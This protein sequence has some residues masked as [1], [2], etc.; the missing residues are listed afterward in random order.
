VNI[1]KEKEERGAGEIAELKSPRKTEKHAI[2]VTFYDNEIPDF[3]ERELERLYQSVYCTI[4]RFNIYGE[5]EGASTYVA[6]V[7]GAVVAA[8]LFRVEAGI[9]RV[10]NQQVRLSDDELRRFADAVFARYGA[11]RRIAFYA[12]DTG[13]E[14][15][16]LPF[17]R[18]QALEENILVLPRTRGDY[19]ASLNQ[20]LYKRLQSGERKLKRDYPDH[21]FRILRGTEVTADTLRQVVAMAS[22][23]MA[24]KHQDTYIRDED[25]DKI[26][27]LIHA[28]GYVGALTINGVIRGGNVFY[29]VGGRYFMHVIAHDPDY[30]KYML[31]HMVQYLSACYCIDNGGTEC[32]LMGGGREN[33]GRFRAYPKYLDSVD[34]YR[35]RLRFLLDARRVVSGTLRRYLYRARE[36]FLQ[37][38]DSD[39]PAGLRA[40]KLLGFVRRLKK[41]WRRTASE[42]K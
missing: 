4:A 17:L 27:R 41:G 2:Q 30:D 35:S 3:V 1:A 36:D 16:H 31:G 37:L 38:A 12:I 5:A 24:S 33:K 25:V 32:C 13:L 29:G 19:T 28:Y 26:L 18:Y 11:A 8:I 20:N 15:F 40:A 10:I 39:T 21:S 42:A 14:R 7:G 6:R 23:R 9:V 34:I 22:A